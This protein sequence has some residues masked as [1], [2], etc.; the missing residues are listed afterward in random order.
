MLKSKKP[1]F[2]KSI[3]SLY[4]FKELETLLNL[5]PFVNTTRFIP[6]GNYNYKWSGYSWQTDNNGWPISCIK[7]VLS[8]QPAYIKD[9]SKA[10]K[11]INNICLK[12]EKIFNK[13]VDCHIYFSFKKGMKGFDKHK[14]KSH[15]Y[16]VLCQG[17]IKVEVWTDKKIEKVMNPGDYVFI[18]AEVY[19]RIVPLTEKRL[20]CSFPITLNE[21]IYFDEREWLTL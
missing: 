8:K 9:C 6:A 2:G 4:S 7:D 17:K 1:H 15:N 3:K 16:I 18:P 21:N 10:N 14:D 11:K 12:L 20:S 19:H 13:P 5:R